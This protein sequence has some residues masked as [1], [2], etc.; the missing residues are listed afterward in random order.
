MADKSKSL[1]KKHLEISNSLDESKRKT[2]ASHILVYFKFAYFHGL[3]PFW[4]KDAGNG[5]S[6]V[7]CT[8]WPQKVTLNYN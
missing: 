4:I 7:V 8:W 3:A 5:A 6:L 1:F 2:L